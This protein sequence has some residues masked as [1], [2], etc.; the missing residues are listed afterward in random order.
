[1][2]DETELIVEI[3]KVI[4]SLS[5]GLYIGYRANL[6]AEKRKEYNLVADPLRKHIK[7]QIKYLDD[8]HVSVKWVESKDFEDLSDHLSYSARFVLEGLVNS[9]EHNINRYCYYEDGVYKINNSSRITMDLNAL[10]NF[11]KRR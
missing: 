10:Q 8:P 5:I 9:Y 4:V 3:I 1:M 6:K 11:L 2:F 7:Q